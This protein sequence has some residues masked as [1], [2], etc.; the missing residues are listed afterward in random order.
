[1]FA[2]REVIIFQ[3]QSKYAQSR[4]DYLVRVRIENQDYEA[5]KKK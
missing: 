3:V 4:V 1:M 2:K 5:R